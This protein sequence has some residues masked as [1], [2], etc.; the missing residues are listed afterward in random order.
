MAGISWN[1]RGWV[2]LSGMIEYVP[3]FTLVPRL[4]LSLRELYARD[5]QGRRGSEIDTAFGLA[6]APARDALASTIVFA[7]GG[8]SEDEEQG[9]VV[10]ME[11]R[12]VLNAGE[13][14]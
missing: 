3:A 8:E 2:V 4:I 1:D 14:A 12:V 5:L 9:E 6:L 11:E 7:D 13:G 10:Q